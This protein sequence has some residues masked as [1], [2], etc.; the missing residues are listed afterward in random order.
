VL[1]TLHAGGTVVMADS[2]SPDEVF[3]LAEREGATLTTLMPPLVALWTDLAPLLGADLSSLTIQVGGARLNPELATRVR[4]ELGAP[5]THWFGMAEGVL[6]HTRPDDPDDAVVNTQGR[7]LCAA[8]ELRVVD[9][10]TGRDVPP[11]EEGELW[12][13]GPYTIRGYYRDERTNANAFTP[14]GFLRTGDLVRF[15]PEGRMVVTGRIREVVNRGG[16]KVPC[17]ELEELLLAH[18]AVRD[19]AVAALPDAVLSEKI[20][21]FVV[22]DGLTAADVVDFLR[23][24]GLAVFKLPDRV[25]FL[26]VLPRTAIGKVDKRAL[27]AASTRRPV[28]SGGVGRSAG[29]R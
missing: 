3:D 16:E 1:G 2:P 27:V 21:A 7:P 19:A 12:V 10:D 29:G 18:P 26:D 8:D 13:R 25:D 9:P 28:E 14:D 6:C 4:T 17:G 15:T 20:G 23:A 11:G 22:A 5:L 24:R